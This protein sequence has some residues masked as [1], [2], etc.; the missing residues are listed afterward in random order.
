MSLKPN[1]LCSVGQTY[2]DF[3]V[4]KAVEIPEL[5]CFLRELVHIP[6]GAQVMHL[7]NDDPENLFCLSFRTHP[8]TSNGVAHILEHTVLCGS[9][10]YPV[11]DPFFAMTRRS[12]NTFMNALTG[13][14]FTCYPAAS[15]VHKDFYNLFEVYL[16]AVFNPLLKKLSF[17]QEGHRLEFVVPTDPTTPLIHKGVVFNEMKGALS[18]GSARLA[19]EMNAALYPDLTYGINSGGDP[20]E[21]PNLTYEQLLDFHRKFYLPSRC[22][23]FFYGNMPLE[24][25]LD[26]I[27]DHTLKNASK[28]ALL[29]PIP[30]QPRFTSPKYITKDYPI[31]PEEDPADKAL[32]AFGWLTSHVLDQDEV[33]ALSIIEIILMD[34]DASPL[35]LA[36]LRSGL[37]KQ[38]S[39][40]MDTDISEVPVVISLKGCE[41]ENAAPLEKII[42]ETLQKIVEDGIPLEAFESAMHQLEF[43]RSEIVGNHAPFGLSLFMRSALISQHGGQPENG[44]VIHS[45]FERLRSRH[46]GDPDYLTGLIKKY[47][48]DNP[49]MVRIT[50]V[51][52]RELNAQEAVEETEELNK[53][54]QQLSLK[55]IEKIVATSVEL[56][57]FQKQQE[58]ENIDVLPKIALS[59]VP[60]FSRE[61]DLH[62]EQVG[63]LK[64]FHHACFTNEI[65]YADLIFDLPEIG[66]QDIP[67]LRLFSIM[68]SQVGSGGRSYAENLDYIQANTGGIGSYIALNIQ[69]N[70]SNQFSPSFGIRG[71]ALYRKANKLFPLYNDILTSLNFDDIPRMKEVLQKHYTS[72]HSTITQS[73][74][75]YSMNL[76]ASGLDVPS[77]LM[78]KW[79]G[80]DYYWFIKKI[81]D[82]I[83]AEIDKVA[84]KLKRMRLEL[85]GLENPHLVITCTKAK[86]DELKRNEFYGLQNM[87]THSYPSWKGDYA[88]P[89]VE[90][91]GRVVASPI[92]FTSHIFKTVPYVHPDTPALGVAACL[93]DNLTLHVSIREQGGAYGGGA[94]CNTTSGNFCFYAYRDPNISKTLS[95]FD[96]A[97]NRIIEGKFEESDLEEAK[98]EVIQSLDAPVAPGSRGE[99]AYGRMREGKTAEV[100]Q[101]FRN[102]LMSLT[103]KD[104]VDAVKSHVAAQSK[105]AITVVFAGRELLERENIALAKHHKPTLPI[106]TI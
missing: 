102:R 70:D 19:E 55:A 31:S 21:I 47:F 65:V 42:R 49:H 100:R 86:Y 4:T 38:A 37:C 32:I 53:I 92:A 66:L 99:L 12:L 30:R 28:A 25:H 41:P 20:K 79:H 26:F 13:S 60:K 103:H 45:L 72:L 6:T 33:L 93:F 88:V 61:Y 14:D 87:V 50:M 89:K 73:S 67:Y 15:Q 95:A 1:K 57:A 97:V 11:K 75:R 81:I 56:I 68:L 90:S 94:T 29:P 51:P 36:L 3:Q 54:R 64:V 8:D 77:Y 82:N 48:L 39:V 101:A 62:Q 104:V 23:F 24:G 74:L 98:L 43:A 59:D 9:Q 52:N 78:N 76:G 63:G 18:S 44:L 85:L 34:T 83:D 22:L 35:K 27:T 96:A 84:S 58:E 2:K 17:L 40:Y 80:L 5:Q 105:E 71:K 10:K 46:F 106:D 69:V 7:S 16:D 91:Q